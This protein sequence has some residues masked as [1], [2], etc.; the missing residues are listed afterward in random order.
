METTYDKTK[1]LFTLGYFGMNNSVHQL[2]IYM[3]KLKILTLKKKL[4]QECIPMHTDHPHT[5]L[6]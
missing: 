4:R 2:K 6:F 5:V 3:Y 1:P